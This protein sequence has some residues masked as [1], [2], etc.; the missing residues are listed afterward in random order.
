[1]S[2]REEDSDYETG[3]ERTTRSGLKYGKPERK[4]LKSSIPAMAYQDVEDQD[5]PA[6][7][8]RQIGYEPM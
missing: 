7:S 6:A 2:D 1:M 3:G 4:A 5:Q 8:S